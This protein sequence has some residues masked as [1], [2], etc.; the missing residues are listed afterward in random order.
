[1]KSTV[2]SYYF[3]ADTLSEKNKTLNFYDQNQQ[4]KNN[5]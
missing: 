3:R 5:L 4:K 1:M 2:H